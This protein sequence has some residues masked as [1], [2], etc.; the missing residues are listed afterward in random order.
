MKRIPRFARAAQHKR[1]VT[2]PNQNNYRHNMKWLSHCSR[3]LALADIDERVKVMRT[4]IV[5]N[6][7]CLRR[8]RLC[9]SQQF[10][11]NQ[12]HRFRM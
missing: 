8:S 12:I 7:I 5:L 4:V 11:R 1:I 2:Q 10:P 6:R 3:W 9:R